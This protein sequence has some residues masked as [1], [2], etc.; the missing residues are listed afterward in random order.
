MKPIFWTNCAENTLE[1]FMV[2][3]PLKDLHQ[4]YP[5]VIAWTSPCDGIKLFHHLHK[6]YPGAILINATRNFGL[7]RCREVCRFVHEN[8]GR[9]DYL[10]RLCPDLVL[11]Q[12]REYL[13]MLEDIGD[14]TLHDWPRRVIGL[15][16]DV[17]AGTLEPEDNPHR[18]NPSGFYVRGGISATSYLGVEAILPH[19]GDPEVYHYRESRR[20]TLHDVVMAETDPHMFMRGFDY[21]YAIAAV[22]ADLTMIH[23]EVFHVGKK[24]DSRFPAIHV[25]KYKDMAR[26]AELMGEIIREHYGK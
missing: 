23:R 2:N 7:T 25:H 22:K 5:L 14:Q 13:A 12:A 18:D 15:V 21:L 16:R 10:I 26:R 17:W 19:L 1:M 24:W 3:T 20:D 4:R 6:H 8:M 9:Y 11:I